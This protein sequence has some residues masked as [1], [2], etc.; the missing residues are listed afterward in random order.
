MSLPYGPYQRHGLESACTVEEKLEA[1]R[2]PCRWRHNHKTPVRQRHF[3]TS[4]VGWK[5]RS[6]SEPDETSSVRGYDRTGQNCMHH[7]A[8]H[9]S[10]REDDA[11]DTNGFPN[12]FGLGAR[13]DTSCAVL[14][15][16]HGSLV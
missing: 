10:K 9:I 14:I 4:I 7:L 11:V 2:R 1:T 15:H 3:T 13:L 8:I 16:M 12:M 6:S 5:Q